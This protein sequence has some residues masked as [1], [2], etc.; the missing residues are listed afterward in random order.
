MLEKTSLENTRCQPILASCGVNAA[1]KNKS[2]NPLSKISKIL[3]PEEIYFYEIRISKF[4]SKIFS[5]DPS[6][7]FAYLV[8]VYSE[9][10]NP[11]DLTYQDANIFLEKNF[12]DL[13]EY[14]IILPRLFKS[15]HRYLIDF[16]LDKVCTFGQFGHKVNLWKQSNGL[17]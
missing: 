11:L 14:S 6:S 13:V 16:Q 8:Q 5:D 2:G 15:H 17:F 7:F 1:L 9:S 12:D 10:D 4:D 3:N